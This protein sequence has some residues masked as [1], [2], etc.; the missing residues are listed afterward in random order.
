MIE[1]IVFWTKN[2]SKNF[3]DNLYVLDELGYKYYFQFTLTPY[4]HSIEIN[5]PQKNEIISNFINLSKKIGKEKIVWRYDPIILNNEYTIEYHIKSFKN[6]AE[7]LELYTKKCIISFVDMYKNI[8]KRLDKN[9]IHEYCEDEMKKI[10]ESLYKIAINYGLKVESCC[11]VIHL[12]NIG[13]EHGHCIDGNLINEITGKSYKFEKDKTQRDV[14]GCIT[15]VD[16]G[17]YNTCQ[18]RCLYC[19]A[20]WIDTQNIMD[21]YNVNSPILCSNISDNDKVNDRVIKKCD[22]L[23]KELFD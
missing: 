12:S 8:K 21:S 9:N 19:Y 20:N 10:A 23:I 15:S 3:I 13:I 7:Q 4:N 1:C 2:P 18:H 17:A 11:E 5:L 22:L 6:I 16:I 14:C